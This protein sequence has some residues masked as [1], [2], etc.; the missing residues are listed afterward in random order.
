M[1][2]STFAGFK[3]ASSALKVSQSLLDVVGQNMANVNNEGYTRQRLDISSVSSSS[4]NLKYG[5]N[6]VA[7]GQGV[8]STG[9]SQCRDAFLDLRYRQQSA[10]T[11]S[12]DIQSEALREL[13]NVFDEIET[14]GLDAQFS[15]FIDQLQ[16]LTSSPSDAVVESVVKTSASML[17][18]I[19][20]NYSDQINTIKDEQT[21]YLRDGAIVDVNQLMKNIAELN[22]EIKKDNISG[23]PALELNDQRNALLDELSSYMDI[24]V[25]LTATPIG[26]GNEIDVL[27]VTLRE[28][29]MKLIDNGEYSVLGVAGAG[30]DYTGIS[31]LKSIDNTLNNPSDPGSGLKYQDGTDI[32]GAMTS[33]QIGGYIKMLNGQGEFGASGSPDDRGLQYY[34]KMLDTLAGKFAE[35]MNDCNRTKKLDAD[36][37]PLTD[38]DGN[39]IYEDKLLFEAEGSG[40]VLAANIKIS[41]AWKN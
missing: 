37:N 19:F 9:L 29:G 41:E 22:E 36:G 39:Y 35:V 14:D 1:L 31:L 40:T 13:E 2:R 5:T 7:I 11:G 21:S 4:S 20:N 33:G 24:E 23:T 18:Q 34:E 17:C 28:S 10:L 15:D 8:V 38:A 26:G 27:S 12:E 32:T 3:T 30:T 16:S 25:N 6:S